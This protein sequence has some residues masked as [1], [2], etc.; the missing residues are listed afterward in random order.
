MQLLLDHRAKQTWRAALIL[1]AAVLASAASPAFAQRGAGVR[2]GISA[3]PDQ[4]FVGGHY[5]TGPVW[6][7][8]RF[9]P[10]VE[11]GFGDDRTLVAFNM[12]FGYWMPLDNQWQAYV[13]GGPA[14]TVRS[15]NGSGGDDAGPGLNVLAGLQWR[16]GL[17]F[18]MKVG[19]FDSPEFKLTVGYTFR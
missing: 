13:G 2:A 10:N 3:D 18:E 9:Q 8:V 6:N 1:W 16:R 4:F 12:E 7:R 14:L 5:V 15:G 11:A 17:F 19:A